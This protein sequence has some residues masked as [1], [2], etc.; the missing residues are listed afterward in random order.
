M[1]PTPYE[2]ALSTDLYELTMA[3]SYHVLQQRGRAVFS[4]YVRKLPEN[5]SFLVV[6]GINEL[7]ERI[8]QLTFDEA[9]CAY[10]QTIPVLRREFVEALQSFRFEGDVWAVRE[11]TVIFPDEPILE[12][13]APID[14]AQLIETLVLNSIHYP[15]LV[16]TKAARCVLAAPGKR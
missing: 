4:L 2:I 8:A 14:Q 11:G 13:E 1:S 15:T 7:L 12:V 6:A 10:L 5:R 3:S 9:A 16:A